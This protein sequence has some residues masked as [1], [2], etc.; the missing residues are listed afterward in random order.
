MKIQ[1][2]FKKEKHNAFTG[3]LSKIALSSNDNKRIQSID[4]I[5]ICAYSKGKC[6]VSEK[7]EFKCRNI[8]TQYKND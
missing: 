7:E 8:I 6:L 4:S 5:E 1:Q 3:E 2:R